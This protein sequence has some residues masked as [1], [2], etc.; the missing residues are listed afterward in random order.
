LESSFNVP[1]STGGNKK[2]LNLRFSPNT[3]DMKVIKITT[4]LKGLRKL[5]EEI[6]QADCFKTDHFTS[7][8]IAF[9]PSRLSVRKQINHHDKD[10]ICQVIKGS[11]RVRVK[12]KLIALRPGMICHI[13]K[14]TPHDFAAGEYGELVLFDSLIRTSE[15]PSASGI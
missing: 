11:G 15:I 12:R 8:L 4:A 10:V 5:N 3:G 1:A 9:R 6:R 13:P 2:N 7:G 14:G